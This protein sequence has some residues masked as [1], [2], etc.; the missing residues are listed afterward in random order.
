[1]SGRQLDIHWLRFGQPVVVLA[2]ILTCLGHCQGHGSF[3]NVSLFSPVFRL[4][5]AIGK[6]VDLVREVLTEQNIE[7]QCLTEIEVSFLFESHYDLLSKNMASGYLTLPKCGCFNPEVLLLW[8]MPWRICCHC[9]D[10][11]CHG[12]NWFIILI[13]CH[14]LIFVICIACNLYGRTN[15]TT[16]VTVGSPMSGSQ[17]KVDAE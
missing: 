6:A 17:L 1:M 11:C 16:P 8:S 13:N 14:W 5:E 10:L 2:L 7:G 9:G 15:A 3:L 12:I 4:D